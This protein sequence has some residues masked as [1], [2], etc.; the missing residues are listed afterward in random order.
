VVVA[1]QGKRLQ[2]VFSSL[3]WAVFAGQWLWHSS[4]DYCYKQIS[5][6]S[7]VNPQEK[8]E[9]QGQNWRRGRLAISRRASKAA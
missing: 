6:G 8:A 9:K 3:I 7:K 1:L 4:C 2:E 5:S